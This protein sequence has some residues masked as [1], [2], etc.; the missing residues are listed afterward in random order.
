M[1]TKVDQ[2]E[3]LEERVEALVGH[4]E[5]VMKTNEELRAK[6]AEIEEEGDDELV[7]LRAQ[8][9]KLSDQVAQLQNEL[10]SAETREDKVR[11]RLQGILKKIDT[12][13]EVLAGQAAAE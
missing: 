6:L 3:M 8:N 12:M 7:A 5:R 4:L 9:H 1:K 11:D 10:Q 13:E 2:L